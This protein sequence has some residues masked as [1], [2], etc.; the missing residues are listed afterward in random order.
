MASLFSTAEIEAISGGRR[1]PAPKDYKLPSQFPSLNNAYGICFDVE[2]V[3]KSIG[4]GTGAGWRRGAYIVGFAMSI[5]NKKYEIEFAEYYPL[6]HKSVQNLNENRVWDWI[7]TELAFHTGEICGANLLY[8]FDGLSY[9]GV[10]APLAKFRD[11]Q[12][13]EA[14]LDENSF[15]YKL[16]ALAKKYLGT[17]K[18]TD[19]LEQMYGKGYITRFH[20]VHPSHART[21]GLGD[22]TLPVQILAAQKKVL[23]KEHLEELFDLECR[24][25]PFLIYMRR[26]GV[27]VDLKQAALMETLLTKR[28]DDAIKRVAVQSGVDLNYDNYGSP[29][30]MKRVFDNLGVAYPYLTGTGHDQKLY[31]PGSPGYEEA[32]KT[33]KPSFRKL[34]LEEG[35]D[36]AISDDILEANIAEKAKGTFV[37]GY[38]GDCAIG[39]RVHCEFHPLRK[40]KDENEKSQGTITGRFSG[41]NPNLQNIPTRDEFIGP[42][43]RSMFIADE[44]AQWWSQDYCV[45]PSTRVLTANLEWKEAQQLTIGEELVGCDEE[46]IH[47]KEQGHRWIRGTQVERLTRLRQPCVRITTDQGVVECSTEHRWLARKGFG[48]YSW[49][50]AK[51][52]KS[53]QVIAFLC[54]PWQE[55]KTHEGGYLA[56]LFDGEGCLGVG[57]ASFNQNNT[58]DNALVLERGINLLREKGFVVSSRQSSSS[59]HYAGILGGR[60]EILRFLGS[61]RPSRLLA[62]A[63]IVWENRMLRSKTTPAARILHVEEIGEQE[64]IA[65]QTDKKTFIAEGFVSHNSQIEYRFLV[66]YA[67]TNKCPGFEVPQA[68][69]LKDP[70]TDFHDMCARLMYG[71]KGPAGGLGWDDFEAQYNTGQI[72][73]DTYKAKLKALRKPAKNLNFGMVYG[74][75][76]AKL[77]NQLGMTN[78]DGTPNAAALQI[79]KDYHAAAPYIRALN[80]LCVSDA[81]KHEFITTILNRRGRFPL[82][83]PRF[84]PKGAPRETA[85]PYDQAKAKWGDK[86]KVSMT[87]KALNKKLQGSAADMMKLAMVQLWEGGIFDE[88]NDITCVLT[89]HDELNGSFVPSARGNE[90]LKEV[91]R[92]METAMTLAIP[93]LTSGST[94]ANWAEAK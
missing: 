22:V 85:L 67:I 81:E 59:T 83:E 76:E 26:L 11:V 93:V 71:K 64:V 14:L 78:P 18:A 52:L 32:V 20:E 13:S 48:T 91:K 1:P 46:P 73:K 30:L 29:V 10:C 77:A 49:R 35:C 39:D 84:T 56:G 34:W 40:K 60:E 5:Y 92:I 74:M 87:H 36:H 33:G 7:T 8:D 94:G 23:H 89:V 63:R 38:I 61:I 27:R 41:S 50:R 68:L 54:K 16:N 80:K 21:Y 88:G 31:T 45:A 51:K 28:R 72:D 44:G 62:K 12:W 17:E 82:Y 47:R 24:L 66:H 79:M 70:K 19:E 15:S 55:D 86:I 43:C 58:G 65:I 4:A 42:L 53:G 69:Y 2:S 9:Q 57:G 75:G 3:D 37:E 90:S 6:R 25:L